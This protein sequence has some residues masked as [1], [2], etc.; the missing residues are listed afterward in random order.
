MLW[1]PS[2]SARSRCGEGWDVRS[3]FAWR[4]YKEK[5]SQESWICPGCWAVKKCTCI[6][7]YFGTGKYYSNLP[8]ASAGRDQGFQR[9]S[10]TTPPGSA[11][12]AHISAASDRAPCS[13]AVCPRGF[14]RDV[15]WAVRGW[16]KFTIG[17]AAG[18]RALHAGALYASLSQLCRQL[19]WSAVAV[20]QVGKTRHRQGE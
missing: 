17:V 6:S 19:F 2:C 10:S 16:N 1:V 12:W 3:S 20:F 9:P 5:R 14:T 8:G 11:W 18:G 13:A 4:V 15:E 7:G